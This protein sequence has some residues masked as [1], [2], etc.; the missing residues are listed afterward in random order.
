MESMLINNW[1]SLLLFRNDTTVILT[2]L[3][4]IIVYV[5]SALALMT[6]ARKTKTEPAWLAWIPLANIYLMGLIAKKEQIGIA[7]IILSILSAIPIVGFL[8]M[9]ANIVLTIIL[10]VG[11][12][13]RRGYSSIMGILMIIPLVNLVIMGVLAWGK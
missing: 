10:W 9:L 12:A 11:I 4:A 6:I 8:A 2:V 3:F 5:Y 7:A 13:Q 1:D